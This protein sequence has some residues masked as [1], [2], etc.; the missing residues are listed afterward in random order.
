MFPV[1]PHDQQEDTR[2]GQCTK[3]NSEQ[4]YGGCDC[5]LLD[6]HYRTLVVCMH[7]MLHIILVDLD[8]QLQCRVQ[9]LHDGSK[10]STCPIHYKLV[11]GLQ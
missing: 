1:D 9:N 10:K 6:G 2:S 8:G 3:K 7:V 5:L 11:M 4:W